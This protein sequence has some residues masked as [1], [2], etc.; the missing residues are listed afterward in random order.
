MEA[1]SKKLPYALKGS[2]AIFYTVF[3]HL[4]CAI[5]VRPVIDYDYATEEEEEDNLRPWRRYPHSQSLP[6]KEGKPPSRIGVGLPELR[7]TDIMCGENRSSKSVSF[8][9]YAKIAVKTNDQVDV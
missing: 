9:A 5:D 1:Q 6:L 3:R 7:V 4:G 2:D 8:V